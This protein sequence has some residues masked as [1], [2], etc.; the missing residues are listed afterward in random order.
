MTTDDATDRSGEAEAVTAFWRGLGLPGIVDVHTH[1]M[2]EPVMAKVWAYFEDGGPL[3]GGPWPITYR[4][5]ELTRLNLLREFGVRAFTSLVYPHKPGMAEWLNAWSAE[6]AAR[7]PGCLQTATFFPEPN[8][9]W[10]TTAAI[11][12]GARVFKVHLQ[13]GNYNPADR[14][15]DDVWGLLEDSGVPVV[16]HC[17][18][19][20]VPGKF[21]G[22]EPMRALL[23]RHPDLPLIIAHLGSPDFVE[24]LDLAEEFPA[25]YLDTTMVFTDFSER[26]ANFPT[27]ELDRLADFSDRILFGSDFP[28]IP[29]RYLD[30]LTALPGAELGEDWLRR[31]CYHNGAELFA[32]H[33]N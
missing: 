13:V 20:P 5:D 14:D 18:S 11:E 24:F 31:V 6:F 9:L 21:T 17:G 26:M 32:L 16:I 28:N 1:F 8:A 19:G 30:A 29:Y 15:L 10:Y 3:I 7:T 22:V 2:P 25:I 23:H 33:E 27:S 12:A 4:D